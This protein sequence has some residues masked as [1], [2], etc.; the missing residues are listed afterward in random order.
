MAKKKA[1]PGPVTKRPVGRPS[2]YRDEYAEQAR[3]LCLLGAIDREMADFFGVSEQTLNAWKKEF[4]EFLEAI[5]AGKLKADAEVATKLYERACGSEWTEQQAFKLKAGKGEERV[6]IVTVRRAV[7]PDTNAI[8][9]FLHN[10]RPDLWRKNA[11][12]PPPADPNVPDDYKYQLE[13]D[14]S[15]PDAPIL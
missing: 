11:T 9:L 8:A 7:P 15:V 2:A 3:K 13:P 1:P 14:E 12:T 5:R 6:E 4:P 10:R